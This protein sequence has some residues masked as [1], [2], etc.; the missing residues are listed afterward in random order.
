MCSK[1]VVLILAPHSHIEHIDFHLCIHTNSETFYLSGE[2][3]FMILLAQAKNT[4]DLWLYI[5]I[6]IRK[7]L[8]AR[9]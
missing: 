3:K 4:H 7:T 8:T 9:P 1:Y 6:I 5:K 2:L